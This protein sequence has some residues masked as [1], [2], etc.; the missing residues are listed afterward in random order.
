MNTT[1][2]QLAQTARRHDAVR[3]IAIF[4]TVAFGLTAVSTLVAQTEGVDVTHIDEATPLGQ[5]AMYAQAFFPLLGTVLARL[6]TPKARRISW[7]FRRSSAH[8]LGFAWLLGL[9]P[10]A[11]FGLCLLGGAVDFDN[12]GL[13]PI[14]PL[15]LSLLVLPYIP[16]AVGEDVGWRGLLVTRLAEVAGPRTV[17]VATGVIWGSFHWPLIIWLGGAPDR[18]A[19]WYAVIAFT[20][21][22]TTLGALLATMQLRWGLWP[23]VITHAVSNAALYHVIDPLAGERA[24]SGYF[25]GECGIVGALLAGVIAL[26]WWRTSPLVGSASGGTAVDAREPRQSAPRVSVG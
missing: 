16:L 19:T 17:V 23:V 12:S 25:I 24:Y 2:E 10:V 4:L 22:T 3:E 9:Y 1:G 20:L 18:T 26:V 7:G 8:A 5:T 14:V 15:G 21:G 11:A 6:S 13:G